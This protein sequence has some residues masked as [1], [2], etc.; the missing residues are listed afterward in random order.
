MQLEFY[1]FFSHIIYKD[2]ASGKAMYIVE[3][4]DE[5]I[6]RKSGHSG[7][8]CIG[9]TSNLPKGMPIKIKG[10]FSGNKTAPI[11]NVESVIP[12]IE[13]KSAALSFLNSKTFH[14]I[15]PAISKSIVEAIGNN[16]FDFCRQE[17]AIEQLTKI[18]G[19]T[20]R[21]ATDLVNKVNGYTKMQE[22]VEYLT[23][24]GASYSSAKKIFE[25]Y[26]EDSLL[27]IKENPYILYFAN[28]SY[29]T[30]EAMA[31]KVGIRDLD[32]RR[33]A[34]ITYEAMDRIETSGNTCATFTDIMESIARID[35]SSN[36]GY[37]TNAVSVLAYL[38][39][40]TNSFEFKNYDDVTYIYRKNMAKLENKAAKHAI[41]IAKENTFL[42]NFK[43]DNQD[44][45]YDEGQT[46]AFDLLTKTGIGILT[47]G[48][49]TGKSTVINGLVKSYKKEY[50][51]H[52]I[53]LAAPT[54]AAAKRL[55]EVTGERA[56]TI[57]KLLDVRPF[58]SAEMQYRDEFNPLNQKLIIVDEFSMVDTELF[59]MLLA[60]I[61]TGSLLILVGDEAQL[62]SVGPG[63]ILK[64]LLENELI[65][66]KKLTE[67][68]RQKGNSTILDNSLKIRKGDT[69]LITDKSFIVKRVNNDIE[70]EALALNY[71]KKALKLKNKF[72][73]KLYS[74]IKKRSYRTSTFNLNSQAHNISNSNKKT[75]L[76]NGVKFSVGDPVI[77]LKNNYKKGYLNGD[78]ATITRINQ[79]DENIS[80]E[81]IM[82]DGG[83]IIL[84]EDELTDMDLAYCITI[85]KSQGNESDAA[86]ILMPQYPMGMLERS[87]A[88]VA[89]TRA[90]VQNVII[91]EGDA[92]EKAILTNQ[93][94]KRRTNLNNRIKEMLG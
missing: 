27:Q 31:K 53:A 25:K 77:M 70:M 51:N 11:I 73:I 19:I 43:P 6:P 26:G 49:G 14:G 94:I 3:S 59:S 18:K 37:K 45:E 72:K 17:N 79:D 62:S 40:R 83:Q 28:V 58:G 2:Q 21:V 66:V 30:R 35:K 80:V 89:I 67:V 60:A 48:P 29:E 4:N 34:A 68:H 46:K 7:I 33:I 39:S 75:L 13:G 88:Y 23:S 93:T 81:L 92:L 5:T 87:L 86:I 78:E 42:G 52:K 8:K 22:L 50:P 12:Q 36:M 41:R 9:Y 76:Y 64:E 55:K 16:L 82:Y 38:L 90:K 32:P 10:V 57:H 54:G 20:N 65:T 56:T 71:M 85:H 47:G 24:F 84:K 61:K 91:S 63:N 44:I 15:G 69:N 1:A 74:P